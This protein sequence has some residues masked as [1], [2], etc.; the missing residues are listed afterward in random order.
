MRFMFMIH[1]VLELRGVS[2]SKEVVFY[3]SNSDMRAARG[4]W[5]LEYYGHPNAKMLDGGF[6]AWLAAGAPITTAATP[7]RPATFKI[8]ERREVSTSRG[9]ECYTRSGRPFRHMPRRQGRREEVGMDKDDL[10]GMMGMATDGDQDSIGE[11]V[12]QAAERGDMDELRRLA[13]VGSK[14]AVDQLVELAQ[15]REDIDE[16]RRLAASGNQDAA[17]ILTELAEGTDDPR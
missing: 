3:G 1:H 15:E 5:F 11:R 12:E 13:A 2:E 9:E 6:Q 8:A 16:L 4:V 14:D 7:P 17:D 10:L